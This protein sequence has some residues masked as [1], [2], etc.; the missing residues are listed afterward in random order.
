[1]FNYSTTFLDE[2]FP[3]LKD[4][5]KIAVI[6]GGDKNNDGS[7]IYKTNNPRSWKSYNRAANDIAHS[8]LKSGFRHVFVFADDMSLVS[9]IKENDIHFAWLNTGGVQGSNSMSHA[10]A[11]LEMAGIP[12]IGHNSLNYGILDN[13]HVFKYLLQQFKLPTSDFVVF[14]EASFPG[15]VEYDQ[16]IIDNTFEPGSGQFIV[17]PVSGRASINVHHVKTSENLFPIISQV[18]SETQNPVIVERFLPGREFCVSIC[19]D[20]VHKNGKFCRNNG[21]FT[22]SIVEMVMDEDEYIFTSMDKK[23]ITNKRV[24]KCD[25]EKDAPIIQQL[26]TLATQV[27]KRFSL[28]TLVRIDF[29][30]D[31]FGNLKILEANPKPDL[32]RPE[33]DTSSLTCMGLDHEGMEYQDLILSIL[34]YKLD[35]LL[36]HRQDSVLHIVNMLVKE[37]VYEA[38]F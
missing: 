33:S 1:M 10:A 36:E 21:P 27:F 20:I 5:L 19:G 7:V 17:K 31:E 29:R 35:F 30:T 37:E 8:L 14:Q 26:K 11:M 18:F 9:K 3:L 12:Y 15:K 24:I 25:H 22:F 28:E 38:S 32:K 6:Y 4:R 13:K 16:L 34:G 23:P 2:I